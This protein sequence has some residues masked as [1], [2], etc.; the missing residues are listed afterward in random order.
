[1][2]IYNSYTRRKEPLQTIKAQ[3]VSL[4]VCGMTVYDYCHIG[5]GRVVVAFDVIRRYLNECGYKVKYIRNITDIDDKIIARAQENG[6]SF[7]DL[8]ERF[9][10]A[11]QQD[12]ATLGVLPPDEEP[13]ATAYIDKMLPFIARLIAKG[14][15][16]VASNGDVYYDVTKFK[17]YGC[18]AHKNI[19]QLQAGIRVAVTE[20]KRNPLDF[21]LWKQAKSGEPSWDSPYGPGRPGWHLECSVMSM[22]CLGEQFDIHGGGFDLQFPHHENEIAQ[23]E[24]VTKK[25][26]VNTWMHVGF[27]QVNHEKMS[28]SLG[29]FFTIRDVLKKYSAEV[30]RY[31][32]LSS[33]YRSPL[34]YSD[35]ALDNANQALK[36]FYT[37]LRDMTP[38]IEDKLLAQPFEASFKSAMDDDFNTPVALATLFDCA[39][40]IN[41]YRTTEPEKAASLATTLKR[42]A[43]ILGILES[44]PIDF[45]K[46][47]H[48]DDT[49]IAEKIVARNQARAEKN[50]QQ[51]DKIREELAAAGI[52]LEDGPQGTTWHHK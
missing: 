26:F 2:Q 23:S 45:L 35:Q 5:H 34:N 8:T 14:V 4:Y 44:D 46:C 18:L 6:E 21:V 41:R 27:V 50:W 9:I 19:D 52:I 51:A 31:F 32:M 40:T 1:M 20:A 33:H 36:R 47:G 11:M 22:D 28:K 25:K 3:E 10:T 15:A 39:R 42:L 38:G 16:Y 43:H 48:M 24:A 29:N 13:R 12:F 17:N 49:V 30:V 37:A 7:H